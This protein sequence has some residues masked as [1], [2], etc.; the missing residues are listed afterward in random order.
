MPASV[1]MTGH[2]AFGAHQ[3]Q[4]MR[5]LD[6]ALSYLEKQ[7]GL[8]ISFESCPVKWRPSVDDIRQGPADSSALTH[9]DIG[10]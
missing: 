2:H 3:L 9:A 1:A 8:T 4:I 5:R 7:Y 10:I 6:R